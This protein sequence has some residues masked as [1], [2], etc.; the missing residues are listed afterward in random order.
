MPIKGL[1]VGR[2]AGHEAEGDLV[3]ELEVVGAYVAALTYVHV[4]A[5]PVLRREDQVNCA[6]T[7]AAMGPPTQIIIELVRGARPADAF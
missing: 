4:P 6:V 2:D 5:V 7:L 3:E 1:D